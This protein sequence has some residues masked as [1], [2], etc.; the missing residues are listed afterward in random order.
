MATILQFD[1]L[2][3]SNLQ[4]CSAAYDMRQPLSAFEAIVRLACMSVDGVGYQP[5]RQEKRGSTRLPVALRGQCAGEWGAS[6]CLISEISQGGL[7]LVCGHTHNPG[8]HIHVSWSE[9]AKGDG[10]EADC[11]VRHVCATHIGVEFLEM[12]DAH[13]VSKSDEVCDGTVRAV[14]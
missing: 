3:A 12:P 1:R 10:M 8:D 6:P 2:G 13:S 11:L 4:L 14:A 5:A 9:G 7:S